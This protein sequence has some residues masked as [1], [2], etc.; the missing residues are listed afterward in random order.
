[1]GHPEGVL[2]G[3]DGLAEAGAAGQEAVVEFVAQAD[4]GD[5]RQVDLGVAAVGQLVVAQDDD[6]VV[7]GGG[8]ISRPADVP[9]PQACGGLEGPLLRNEANFEAVGTQAKGGALTD[10]E[11]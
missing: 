11:P 6:P 9:A 5:L 8:N 10:M 4:E 3:G 2:S 1:M 7:G